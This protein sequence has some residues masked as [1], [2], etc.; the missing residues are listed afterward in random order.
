MTRQ[1]GIGRCASCDATFGYMLVHNG[2]NDSAYAYCDRCGTTA[3]F[4]AYASAAPAGVDVGFHG[5]LRADAEG[6][7]QPCPCGGHFS[8]A[9]SPR[10]PHCHEEL[11]ASGAAE[12]IERNA[13][14]GPRGWR[15]QCSWQGT[16]ALVIENRLL[17][18][19]WGIG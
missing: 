4:S 19:P 2:F 8:G 9:A 16:Y 5:P 13:A 15:W 10:C 11:S 12:Y 17:Q 7:A 14:A 18:D 1:D 3:L 6:W